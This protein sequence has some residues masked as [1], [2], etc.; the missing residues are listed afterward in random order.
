MLSSPLP[1]IL[2]HYYEAA[3]GPFRN[4]SGLAPD[5]ARE[6]LEMI[7][8]KAASFAAKRND[9]Y[10]SIRRALEL[11]VRGLFI[12]KGGLPVNPYPH[13]LVLGHVPWLL[14]WYEHGEELRVPLSACSARSVSFTYGD[15]FHAM[16]YQDGRAYRGQVF[17]LDELPA[18]VA[19]YGLPQEWNADGSQGP[20]RYIEA[21]V[22]SDEPLLPYLAVMPPAQ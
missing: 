14:S 5:T 11:H 17:T 20:D 6:V 2:C 4:L 9:N 22:W 18:L 15:T 19:E 12:A 10:L 8:L 21:Q 16:R 1:D 7:K 13:Y 3:H